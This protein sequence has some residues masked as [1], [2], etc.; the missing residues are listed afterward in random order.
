MERSKRSTDT[1]YL[2]SKYLR[3][4]PNKIPTQEDHVNAMWHALEGGCDSYQR[5]EFNGDGV[6]FV[7]HF[8]R[9]HAPTFST[10]SDDINRQISIVIEDCSFQEFSYREFLKNGYTTLS[11][12]EYELCLSDCLSRIIRRESVPHSYDKYYDRHP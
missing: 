6:I 3:S 10:I 8:E 11:P 5:V 2:Y 9:S 4:L 7:Y 1:N 12:T